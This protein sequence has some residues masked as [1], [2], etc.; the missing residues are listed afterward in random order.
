L[1]KTSIRATTKLT[2]YYTTQL[3]SFGSLGP[4]GA[5]PV[6]H[7]RKILTIQKD[8]NVINCY[9]NKGQL[10]HQLTIE[11]DGERAERAGGLRKTSIRASSHN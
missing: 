3:H 8:S 5:V 9:T 10:A 1:R 4:L 6:Y 11:D 2:L 7:T